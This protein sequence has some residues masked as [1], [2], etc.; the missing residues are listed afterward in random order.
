MLDM[1]NDEAQT[2]DTCHFTPV[3]ESGMRRAYEHPSTTS[4]SRLF[5]LRI[6]SWQPRK[7]S[8]RQIF[9]KQSVDQANLAAELA[10][11]Q[12]ADGED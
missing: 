9:V 1:A 11:E 5:V 3:A 8:A 6:V 12:T 4:E 10:V 7:L 2:R